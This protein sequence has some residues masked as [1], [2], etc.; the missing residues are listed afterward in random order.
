M[1]CQKECDFDYNIHLKKKEYN[2]YKNYI[3]LREMLNVE[4][5]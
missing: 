3:L 1:S 2:T 5:E 4:Y